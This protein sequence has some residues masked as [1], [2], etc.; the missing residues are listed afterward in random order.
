MPFHS[1][2][3]LD[4]IE[5]L[6]AKKGGFMES[7][8]LSF[9]DCAGTLT[10]GN[11]GDTTNCTS[12]TYWYPSGTYVWSCSCGSKGDKALRIVKYLMDEK[13]VKI[14][15]IKDFVDLLDKVSSIL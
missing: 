13:M 11:T 9:D 15:K 8:V 7:E 14:K 6:K 4:E 12:T 5:Q 2:F 3:T 10:T 1:G